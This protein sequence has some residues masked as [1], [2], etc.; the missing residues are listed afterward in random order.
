M[1][2]LGVALLGKEMLR[3]KVGQGVDYPL[4]TWYTAARCYHISG[5]CKPEDEPEDWNGACVY[6]ESSQA[7]RCNE[8]AGEGQVPR[9]DGGESGIK[10]EL[11][12]VCYGRGI[13]PPEKLND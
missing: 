6:F 8:C 13:Q 10:T 11:C 5:P 12:P 9:D 2:T 7:P 1:A 4:C 3:R